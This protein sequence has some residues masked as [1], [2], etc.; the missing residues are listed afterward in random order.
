MFYLL[1]IYVYAQLFKLKQKPRRLVY[2]SCIFSTTISSKNP[3]RVKQGSRLNA[4]KPPTWEGNRSPLGS[5]GLGGQARH[6][7]FTLGCHGHLGKGRSICDLTSD[8]CFLSAV[9]AQNDNSV[10]IRSPGNTS[11][12]TAFPHLF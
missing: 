1:S 10:W 8:L 3:F 11:M 12:E 9:N 4:D 7:S 6:L 5:S 2:R